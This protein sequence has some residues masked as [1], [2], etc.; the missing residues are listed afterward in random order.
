MHYKPARW[1]SYPIGSVPETRAQ[2]FSRITVH[3]AGQKPNG[4]RCW[5]QAPL[6][7]V[8]LPQVTWY[9]IG[10]RLRCIECGNV[11]Y[12]SLAFDWGEL[13]DMHSAKGTRRL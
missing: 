9:E 2:G 10:C 13:I 4:H 1:L 3:C 8:S 12:V 6:P 5:H 7:L 11:G